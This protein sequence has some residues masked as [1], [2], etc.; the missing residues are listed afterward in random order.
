M[1]SA[2]TLT[3][4]RPP[5]GTLSRRGPVMHRAGPPSLSRLRNPRRLALALCPAWLL[6]AAGC[7]HFLPT[8]AVAPPVVRGQ[9]PGDAP[10]ARLHE[11]VVAQSAAQTAS[12]PQQPQNLPPPT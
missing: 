12:P 9:A 5:G 7:A 10:P 11:P 6:L 4:A 3:L 8:Q 2:R 1:R